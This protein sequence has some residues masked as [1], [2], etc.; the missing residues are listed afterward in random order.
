MVT[1]MLQE[2]EEILKKSLHSMNGYDFYLY[3]KN[4]DASKQEVI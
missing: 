2:R 4:M 3:S 1:I